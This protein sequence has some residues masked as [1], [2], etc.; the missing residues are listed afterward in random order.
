VCKV[1]VLDVSERPLSLRQ[2]ILRDILSLITLPILFVVEIPQVIRGVDVSTNPEL[3]PGMWVL[4]SS[5]LILF[6]IEIATM[7]TNQ[8]RRALHDYI[9]GSVVIRKAS[10]PPSSGVS[11]GL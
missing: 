4:L 8:K 7:L 9:A 10:L 5:G 6:L 3:S 2:A 1:I 11:A